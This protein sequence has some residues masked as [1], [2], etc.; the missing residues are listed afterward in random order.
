MPTEPPP[1]PSA[2]AALRRLGAFALVGAG[3]S[4]VY[5]FTGL[6]VPCPFRML[7]GWLCPLCGATHAGAA[8]LSGDFVGAWLANPLLIVAAFL[9]GLRALGWLV[10]LLK[11][12]RATTSPRW[13][14]WA[15]TR[16]WGWLAAVVGV[17]YVLARNLF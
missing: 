1:A 12:P 7:T 11:D 14:P 2:G 15:V 10:E 16:R 5:L 8:L 9:I 17:G 13:I 4:G 6:G 3:I